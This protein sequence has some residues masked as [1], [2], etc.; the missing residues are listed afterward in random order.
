MLKPIIIAFLRFIHLFIHLFW[1]C[2]LFIAAHG[3]SLVVVSGDSSLVLVHG[4]LTVAS[5]ADHRP[6][7]TGSVAVAYRLPCTVARGIFPDQG[8]N[9]VPDHIP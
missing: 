8:L 4:L 3:L 7:G 1:L 9:H 5:L 6:Q 2:W